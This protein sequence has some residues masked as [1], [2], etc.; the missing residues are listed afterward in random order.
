VQPPPESQQSYQVRFD[1]GVVGAHA[2]VAD[3]DALVWVD[4]LGESAV[5]EVDVPVV[6]GSLQSAEAVAAWAL[7]R[8]EALGGRFRIAVAAAGDSRADGSPR[9]AVEDLL[10]AGAVIDA[11]SERGIDHQSPEAAAAASSYVG[12]RRATRHLVSASV[13][14][15]STPGISLDLSAVDQVTLLR[16]SPTA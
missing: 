12:L 15:R 9:F 7:A 2:I 3:A 6:A 16:E 14:A 11:I 13:T 5:P 8:Q 4:Q 1:W 10:A